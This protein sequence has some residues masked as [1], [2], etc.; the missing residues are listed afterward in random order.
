MARTEARWGSSWS[1]ASTSW[2]VE[3][4]A[5]GNGARLFHAEICFGVSTVPSS[6]SGG[7]AGAADQMNGGLA[8]VGRGEV[9]AVAEGQQLGRMAPGGDLEARHGVGVEAA[10]EAAIEGGKAM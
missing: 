3:S 7:Q 8:V 10:A 2:A 5:C 1:V 4:R 9:Q 6:C